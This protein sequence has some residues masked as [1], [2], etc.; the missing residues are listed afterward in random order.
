MGVRKPPK[1][2]NILHKVTKVEV[3]PPCKD[4]RIFDM[5][6]SPGFLLHHI[7]TYYATLPKVRNTYLIHTALHQLVQY[8][9]ISI[10][11]QS[12]HCV[13]SHSL[14]YDYICSALKGQVRP[15]DATNTT[16]PVV[17]VYFSCLPYRLYTSY[18]NYTVQRQVYSNYH[19]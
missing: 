5:Q 12:V 14:Y 18:I 19:M 13:F 8:K 11:L 4:Y 1:S 2:G 15:L 17:T 10:Q 6:N 3:G 16:K 7:G 9:P